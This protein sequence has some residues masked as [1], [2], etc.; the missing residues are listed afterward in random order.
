MKKLFALLFAL[1]MVFALAACGEKTDNPSGNENNPGT[2]QGGENNNGGAEINV[3]LD[4]EKGRIEFRATRYVVEEVTDK[5]KEISLED[6]Q[7]LDPNHHVADGK[8]GYLAEIARSG[9]RQH[10]LRIL[11]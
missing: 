2:S 4:A 9:T 10:L 5:D 7:E 11:G 6:A 8:A 1:M 3:S